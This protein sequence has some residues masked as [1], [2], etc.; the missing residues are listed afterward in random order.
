MLKRSG[1]ADELAY[2]ADSFRLRQVSEMM[3]MTLP[4]NR[5]VEEVAQFQ[6]IWPLHPI[7]SKPTRSWAF[8][9][10]SRSGWRA[11]PS[12]RCFDSVSVATTFKNKLAERESF[13]VRF[14]E[15]VHDH[16]ELVENI[17][18]RL[19]R[20]TDN[21]FAA[22]NSAVFTDGSFCLYSERRALPDGAFD[23]FPD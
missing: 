20:T 7:C 16:P 8:H 17:W 10:E 5:I 15:A 14:T 23:L 13:S 21:F 22:L 18:D 4:S 3:K 12:T 6:Q 19:C 1:L 9:S 2:S 11:S